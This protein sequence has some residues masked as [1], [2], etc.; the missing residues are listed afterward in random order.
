MKQ[1]KVY[2]IVIVG[3]GTAGWSTAAL[4]SANE[5]FNVTVVDPSTIPTIGVGES[6]LP[7]MNKTHRIMGFDVF[8][9][10]L[11]LDEVE[12]TF[13]FSIFFKDF[14][15]KG[16]SWINPFFMPTNL[17]ADDFDTSL[18][19]MS[20]DLDLSFYG[21][22]PSYVTD[23]YIF[24]NMQARGFQETSKDEPNT[25]ASFGGYHINASLYG[26]LLRTKT[27]ER[28]NAVRIDSEVDQIIGNDNVE[29]LI[30]KDGT[31]LKADLFVDCTGFKALLLN[32]LNSPWDD[33]YNER[34]LVDTAVA[35]Q[36]PYLNK[37]VQ[38]RNYTHCHAL[39]NG[40]IWNVPLQS[41]IGTG[42]IFSSRHISTDEATQR[43]TDY[44]VD[45][46]GYDSKDISPRKVPFNT[47]LRRESWKGN[48]VGV[49]LSSFFLEPIES[50][51][52]AQLHVQGINIKLLLEASHIPFNLKA[53]RFN[54]NNNN[55]IDGI[56]NYI[57]AHY[58]FSERKDSKFW[59]DVTSMPLDRVHKDMLRKF[60]DPSTHFDST[61][62][63]SE[64]AGQ[65]MFDN[66]TYMFLL[67]GYGVGPN[68]P[69]N[70]ELSL[71]L[72]Q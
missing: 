3:G 17:Y 59:R 30:L 18:A 40:W 32:H 71:R 28:S 49:G 16:S 41:R 1:K 33:S 25:N 72:Q 36:L 9:N 20:G 44:L 69:L 46:Y 13:K 8:E 47:G 14:F 43:F 67:L 42:Y 35:V 34:L 39:E 70:K 29:K 62:I 52:I 38:Q 53:K 24:A 63:I 26:N 15:R 68:R 23:N 2:N 22:Q 7:H 37:E 12:G 19:T 54:L 31:E 64:Y 65:S 11:W 51:A 27:L 4:L 6:T 58:L 55:A 10:S 61:S 50:T 45:T 48:V 21:N 57:E 66:M 5:D 56:A 60:A